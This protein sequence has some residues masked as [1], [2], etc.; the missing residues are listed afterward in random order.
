MRLNIYSIKNQRNY[1]FQRNFYCKLTKFKK[2]LIK[3]IETKGS[4]FD[5]RLAHERLGLPATPLY[6]PMINPFVTRCQYTDTHLQL[7]IAALSIQIHDLT[8][9][10]C[11]DTVSKHWQ[12]VRQAIWFW[13]FVVP[14]FLLELKF[15][16]WCPYFSRFERVKAYLRNGPSGFQE[17][18]YVGT[19][20]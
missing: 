17:L 19:I 13:K 4:T 16:F 6:S 5:F 8:K 9:C 12:F 15:I 10:W 14:E 3:K 1:Y 2:R 20:P 7:E 11:T 18:I